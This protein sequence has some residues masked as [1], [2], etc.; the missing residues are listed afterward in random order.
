MANKRLKTRD[1]I[2]N[3]SIALFNRDGVA[4]V[5]T[6]HIAE[7]LEI[8]PGNLYYYFSN[9][10]EIIGAIF[11]RI[12]E[13]IETLWQEPNQSNPLTIVSDYIRV[14]FTI[15]IEYRF[16][17]SDLPQLLRKDA[18]LRS[19][20]VE[21][22]QRF[23]RELA[24]VYW[25]LSQ[26]GVFK[27]FNELK[28]CQSLATNTWIVAVFWHCYRDPVQ[29]VD[30]GPLAKDILHQILFLLTP[31]IELPFVAV[32][33]GLFDTFAKTYQQNPNSVTDVPLEGEP[34]I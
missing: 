17:F 20:Y 8:S 31:Y 15:L 21:L 30:Q 5:S 1:R 24:A 4:D 6:N 27:G 16:F 2:I 33:G 18:K 12:Q 26:V 10:E 13:Q 22:Q 23:E 11:D 32:V 3:G 14:V 25:H 7:Y 34:E 19:D 29:S 28:D 9:K